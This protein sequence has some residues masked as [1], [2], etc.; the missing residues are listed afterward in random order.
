[1]AAR[2]KFHRHYSILN[3][4]LTASFGCDFEFRCLVLQW[5]GSGRGKFPLQL[6]ITKQ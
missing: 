1:M 4:D 2:V 5:V 6:K 3:V